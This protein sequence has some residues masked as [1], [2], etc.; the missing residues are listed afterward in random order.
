[1]KNQFSSIEAAIRLGCGTCPYKWFWILAY[2]DNQE[3]P[4]FA[5][6]FHGFFLLQDAPRQ[7]RE[8][9][10]TNWILALVLLKPHRSKKI[11]SETWGWRDEC[12]KWTSDPESTIR[13]QQIWP[14]WTN[15]G[16]FS[17]LSLL[18][19]GSLKQIIAWVCLDTSDTSK[20]KATSNTEPNGK[21]V[22][23]PYWM[24]PKDKI[25]S[26]LSTSEG[27]Y[28][29]QRSP[30]GPKHK[31]FRDKKAVRHE[32]PQKL[33]FCEVYGKGQF[34]LQ[35]DMNSVHK[36]MDAGIWTRAHILLYVVWIY[37]VYMCK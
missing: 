30:V 1:M 24:R 3:E 21:E 11:A 36:E 26:R 2:R 7:Y 28:F 16:V 31:L 22:G 17:G 33:P 6:G 25:L 23:L 15:G 10:I 27:F 14:Q 19:L 32:L 18:P 12:H 4:L 29:P 37:R 35:M 8:E 13:A 5:L 34:S 20:S 9:D